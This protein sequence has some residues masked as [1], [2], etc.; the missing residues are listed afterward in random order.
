LLNSQITSLETFNASTSTVQ[1]A[2]VCTTIALGVS[3][4]GSYLVTLPDL[5][6]TK[7]IC[8]FRK[9][10]VSSQEIQMNNILAGI[11]LVTVKD[12]TRKEVK[13]IMVN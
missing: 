3:N 11:Y 7:T 5:P 2:T 1:N 6:L 12:G 13:K 10:G 8:R 9:T 4:N